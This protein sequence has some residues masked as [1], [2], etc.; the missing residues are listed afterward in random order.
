M[1]IVEIRQ[2]SFGTGKLSKAILYYCMLICICLFIVIKSSLV[3]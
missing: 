2:E 3:I 1:N